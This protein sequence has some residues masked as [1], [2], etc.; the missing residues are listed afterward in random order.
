MRPMNESTQ[1]YGRRSHPRSGS[2]RGYEITA[3]PGE[4]VIFP[5]TKEIRPVEV[6]LPVPEPAA[7]SERLPGRPAAVEVRSSSFVS[8][9]PS[10]PS[11]ADPAQADEVPAGSFKY[12]GTRKDDSVSVRARFLPPRG[13]DALG[14]G[15]FAKIGGITHFV[16]AVHNSKQYGAVA[17]DYVIPEIE[18]VN[19]RE[20]LR[21]LHGYLDLNQVAGVVR[22]EDTLLVPITDDSEIPKE[23]ILNTYSRDKL[24]V[25]QKVFFTG[26]PGSTA[27]N[28]SNSR[29]AVRVEGHILSLELQRSTN[30][31]HSGLNMQCSTTGIVNY[32]KTRDDLI[33]ASGGAVVT[34]D[35][36]LI[37]VW[38]TVGLFTYQSPPHEEV[39]MTIS[40]LPKR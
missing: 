1:P 6:W 13:T 34:E 25:G 40:L 3:G 2:G 19:G 22:D 36:E 16:S 32:A 8:R 4:S 14:S 15:S 11:P 29:Q 35:G 21:M 38:S 5:Q 12:L 24:Q 33:A 37:G 7:G 10:A 31:E 20:I 30:L 27:N 17:V 23:M 39:F 26:F 28:G 18:T 9:Q